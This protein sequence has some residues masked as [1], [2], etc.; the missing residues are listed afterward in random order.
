M[1]KK[2]HISAEDQTLFNH[3]M[4]DVTPLKKQKPKERTDSVREPF[5]LRR[6]EAVSQS[7]EN[8][9]RSQADILILQDLSDYYATAVQSESHLTYHQ[10]GIGRMQIQALRTGQITYQAKLDLHGLKA[11][12]AKLY[13]TQFLSKQLQAQH[14]W[15]LI[16]HGK[17]GRFGEAPVLKNLVNHWLQQIPTVLAFHS[18]QPKHGGAGAVYVLLKTSR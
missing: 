3:E 9:A 13:L 12:D 11:D 2:N 16:I 7:L 18:A 6:R 15:V 14:R 5:K 17:G 10:T 8:R 1:S 4:R